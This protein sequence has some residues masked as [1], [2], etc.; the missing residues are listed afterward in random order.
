MT[1]ILW[2]VTTQVIDAIG[3][4]GVRSQNQAPIF[5]GLRLRGP[6]GHLL[7]LLS[8]PS[9]DIQGIKT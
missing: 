9:P 2:Q 5:R 6:Y 8:K 7:G 3:V 1:P 4:F